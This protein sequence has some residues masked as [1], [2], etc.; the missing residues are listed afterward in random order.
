MSR[1]TPT[2]TAVS[3][4]NWLPS[5][6]GR[7]LISMLR[8]DI[9]L[10]IRYGLYTLYAAIVALYVIGLVSLPTAVRPAVVTVVVFTDPVF[11]G[12]LFTGALV[13][14]EKGDG[15]LNALAVSPLRRREY[16]L[17]KTL[18]LTLLGVLTGLVIAVGGY[19]LQFD[20]GLFLLGVG[21]SSVLF[22]LIGVVAVSRFDTVNT[23]IM[24]AVVYLLPA[25]VPLVEFIGID[26]PLLYLIPTKATLLLLGGAFR[27]VGPLAGWELVYAVGYL[28][29]WIVGVAVLADR[30]FERHIVRGVNTGGGG[31]STITV[32]D[33]TRVF[34]DRQ[35]GPVGTLALSELRTWLRDPLLTYLFILPFFYAL[36]ARLTVPVITTWVAPGFDLL[37]YYPVMFGL[38]AVMSPFVIGIA[39]GLLILE[40]KEEN[41]LAAL[42]TTP[43]TGRGYLAYRG[44]S[45]VLVSFVSMVLVIPLIGLVD[46][47]IHIVVLS[48]GVGALWAIGTAFVISS[49]AANTVEGLAVSKFV[50]F[51][52]LIPMFAI[53]VVPEPLQFLAGLVPVYWPLKALV[54]GAVG[55][56]FQTILV[57]LAIGIVA[58][59]LFIGAFVRRFDPLG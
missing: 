56:P 44:L 51:S 47:P 7:R 33:I 28:T 42:W 53:A 20:L 43:L 32:P 58:H 46:V 4:R 52:L 8:W 49:F 17:S 34:E 59:T 35:F 23:Y 48:A 36:L 10:Q 38:F 45:M 31:G 14:F 5:V 19:G 30:A 24:A 22:V 41:V 18:S 39:T 15:V 9:Q 2:E 26:H 27:A 12:L 57:Y 21:L 55:T 54:G 29:L 50:S 13:L 1:A 6:S 11:L 16:L 40:E 3:I 37:P 25:V